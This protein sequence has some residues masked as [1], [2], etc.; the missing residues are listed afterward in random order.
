MRRMM[1]FLASVLL[2]AFTVLPAHGAELAGAT[3]DDTLDM[4]GSTL[5]LS[6]M[7][8]REKF[9]FDVYVAGLYL[10]E[11]RTDAQVILETDEPRIMVMHFLR[12]VEAQK[13]NDAWMQGLEDNTP[14]ADE[15]LKAK[16]SRLCSM[17]QDVYKGEDMVFSYVPGIGTAIETAQTP[18]G[19]IQG[20]DFTDALLSTWI[21]PKPGPGKSF[22]KAL[23]KE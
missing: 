19:V 14:E 12:T 3:L 5:M 20:K 13:I 8:L 4:E 16:F 10:P 6:G 15:E 18:K 1:L 7:A 9:V 23:L 22:R 11:K 2:A 21:G 17:M